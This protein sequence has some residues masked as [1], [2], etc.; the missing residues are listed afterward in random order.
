MKPRTFSRGM[1]RL[2]KC[3]ALLVTCSL[4]LMIFAPA[5]QAYR[6]PH[7]ADPVPIMDTD[8]DPWDDLYYLISAKS[9]SIKTQSFPIKSMTYESIIKTLLKFHIISIFAPNNPKKSINNNGMNHEKD[10]DTGIQFNT[11]TDRSQTL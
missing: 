10:R 7:P 3:V 2:R 4:L 9:E 11:D 5:S 8:E 6:T 1:I